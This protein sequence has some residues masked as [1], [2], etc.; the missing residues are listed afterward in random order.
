[1]FRVHI[2]KGRRE[3]RN[4]LRREIAVFSRSSYNIEVKTEDVNVV[5]RDWYYLFI[6]RAYAAE[7]TGRGP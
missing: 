2:R 6:S 1:L 7:I 3:A 5:R 4:E